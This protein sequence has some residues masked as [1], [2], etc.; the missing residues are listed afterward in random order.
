VEID[1]AAPGIGE[2]VSNLMLAMVLAL[3]I[4]GVIR[5]N[6]WYWLELT[7]EERAALTAAGVI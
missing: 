1:K 3:V 2:V 5:L 6:V 4:Q 7:P